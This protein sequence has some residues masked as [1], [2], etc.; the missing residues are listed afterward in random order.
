M[1]EY[2][3][4]YQFDRTADDFVVRGIFS[5]A[6]DAE[7]LRL[8]INAKKVGNTLDAVVVSRTLIQ[9][10]DSLLCERLSVLL[11]VGDTNGFPLNEIII[12]IV[13]QN[14]E[15]LMHDL[16]VNTLRDITSKVNIE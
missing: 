15:K 13:P 16:K 14:V 6:E 9:L 12:H 4:V 11:K 10:T 3:V 8:E 7:V 1:N 2:Q 5:K